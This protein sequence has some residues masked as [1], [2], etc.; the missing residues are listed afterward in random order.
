M[1][2][3]PHAG[4]A[5]TLPHIVMLGARFG[6]LGCANTAIAQIELPDYRTLVVTRCRTAECACMNICAY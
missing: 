4:S 2:A 5:E 6:G 3:N 1:N